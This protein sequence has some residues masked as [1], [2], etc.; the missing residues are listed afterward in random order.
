V[1]LLTHGAYQRFA[2]EAAIAVTNVEYTWSITSPQGERSW[3]G[4]CSGRQP[5]AVWIHDAA[6]QCKRRGIFTCRVIMET[7]HGNDCSKIHRPARE[8]Y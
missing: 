8:A 7:F 6:S 5:A 1:T 4:G 2:D 3:I